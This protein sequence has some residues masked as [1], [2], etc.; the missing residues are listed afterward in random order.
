[1]FKT[2]KRSI[3]ISTLFLSSTLLT[4]CAQ[5]PQ[6]SC[7]FSRI[8][9]KIEVSKEIAVVIA[10]NKGFV[11]FENVLASTVPKV[12]ELFRDKKNA[13]LS[14]V[15]ADGNPEIES[16]SIIEIERGGFTQT[17]IDE[18]IENAVS[19]IS[20]V[21]RCALGLD[22]VST[23]SSGESNLTLAM[24][25]AAGAF[26]ATG[27]QREIFVLSNGVST[28]GQVNFATDEVP[29]EEGYVDKVD[30]YESAL[31]NLQGANVTWI[32]LGQTDGL[33]QEAFDT[34]V[35]A[36]L[37][38]FWTLFV[39][40]SN[41]LVGSISQGNVVS[42]E[43]NSNSLN[44]SPVGSGFKKVCVSEDLGKDQGVVFKENSVEFKNDSTA[45]A[46]I[47]R[48]AILI[49]KSEC[50]G[51]VMVTGSVSSDKNKSDFDGI[52][53]IGLSQRRA[54]VVK[55][56]LRDFGVSVEI[57][58]TGKGFGGKNEWDSEGTYINT[59][60]EKNRIVTIQEQE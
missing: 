31:I 1:M 57:D 11:D 5:A 58:A 3:L 43:P 6:A 12:Q 41:G 56:L 9:E 42:G 7:E 30:D 36:A 52:G 32:G 23:N 59:L 15:L 2:N 54:D 51:N 29:T 21:Y 53:D 34:Q 48:I 26:E 20:K 8:D 19:E 27:S 60:G 49:N 10:P 55:E 37:S 28:A 24:S 47:E 22:G 4:S 35:I 50:I 38:K 45:L 14:I 13:T 33:H 16:S 18:E 25:K 17:D 40:R 39:E 44:I 46:S